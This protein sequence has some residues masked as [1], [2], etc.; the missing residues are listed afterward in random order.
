MQ[1]QNESMGSEWWQPSNIMV[2]QINPF[3]QLIFPFHIGSLK[4][5][6]CEMVTNIRKQWKCGA[7]HNGATS[8]HPAN[9][10]F[11]CIFHRLDQCYGPLHTAFDSIT[12]PVINSC[13][14]PWIGIAIW[15][16]PPG[17][18]GTIFTI[19]VQLVLL[20]CVASRKSYWRLVLMRPNSY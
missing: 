5:C 10:I 7:K 11:F 6:S 13:L 3:C 1:A 9:W 20:V 12:V 2:C 16:M 17:T 14:W 19:Y 8:T 4:E 15:I 18:H